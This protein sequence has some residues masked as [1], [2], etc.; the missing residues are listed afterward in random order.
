MVKYYLD[1]EANNRATLYTVEDRDE[2]WSGSL[3]AAGIE[4]DQDDQYTNKLD[5]FFEKELGISP[6][7]WEIG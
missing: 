4:S 5:A 2:V 7:E 1:L 6:D 3:S